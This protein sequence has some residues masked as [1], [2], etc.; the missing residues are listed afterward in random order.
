VSKYESSVLLQ[1]T[2]NE[3]TTTCVTRV[4]VRLTV[5]VILALE[6][7]EKV[8]VHWPATG[9]AA[10]AGDP[11][12]RRPPSAIRQQIRRTAQAYATVFRLCQ[13]VLER[14]DAFLAETDDLGRMVSYDRVAGVA[15]VG[16]EDGAH[17]VFASLPRA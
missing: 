5:K 17:H 11:A 15:V 3:R 7:V 4:P 1:K 16:N 8:A 13:R 2:R 14:C 6:E 9:L 12:S 10:R